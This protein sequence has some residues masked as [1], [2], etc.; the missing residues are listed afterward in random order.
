MSKGSEI[1]V[2]AERI[3]RRETR[4][5]II[6]GALSFGWSPPHQVLLT[7][8]SNCGSCSSSCRSTGIIESSGDGPLDSSVAADQSD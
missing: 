2:R 4:Q 6:M 3:V 1:D 5:Q 7:S 8:S